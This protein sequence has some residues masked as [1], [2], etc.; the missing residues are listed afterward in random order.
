[1][2]LLLEQNNGNSRFSTEAYQLPA[3]LVL[4]VNLSGDLIIILKRISG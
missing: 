1:M 3:Q 2:N 4:V